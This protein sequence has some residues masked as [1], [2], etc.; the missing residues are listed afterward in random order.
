MQTKKAWCEA[1][2]LRKVRSYLRVTETVNPVKV[3]SVRAECHNLRKGEQSLSFEELII[4]NEQP[5]RDDDSILFVS[6]NST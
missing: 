5:V 2:C 3:L 1:M 6:M 4:R